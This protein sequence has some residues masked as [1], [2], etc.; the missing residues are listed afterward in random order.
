MFG[1]AI[2]GW[3][4]LVAAVAQIVLGA[5]WYS[6]VL[7]GKMWSRLSGIKGMGSWVNMVGGFVVALVM[8][9]V[10]ANVVK[11]VGVKGFFGGITAGF[12][13]WLGF[14]ATFTFYTIM[15]ER[16]PF[17]LYLIN[18]AYNLLGLMLMG[19]ILSVW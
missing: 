4:V 19:V 18:N 12:W 10:L 14:V 8:S 15:Y 2:N 16:K 1:L 11:Y 6:P 3:A 7:F 17:Q 9:F 13:M 5:L